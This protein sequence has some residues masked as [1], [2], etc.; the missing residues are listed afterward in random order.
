MHAPIAK[1]DPAL[2]V[3]VRAENTALFSGPS[4]VYSETF[5]N[6][7]MWDERGL[8]RLP[9]PELPMPEQ[10]SLSLPSPRAVEAG[11]SLRA[12][13]ARRH[14]EAGM[15]SLTE[16]VGYHLLPTPEAKLSDSGPDYA[17]ANRAGSGGDD[18]VTTI[19]KNLLGDSSRR[20]SPAGKVSSEEVRREQPTL[21][22]EMGSIDSALDSWNG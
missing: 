7:V 19:W 10:G 20:R 18:L 16:V 5:P 13:A 22:D 14:V 6:W 2:D 15:G 11:F 9:T 1:W 21:M 4:T 3:W 8:S 12:P 17:R